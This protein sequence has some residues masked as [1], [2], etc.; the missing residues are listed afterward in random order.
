MDPIVQLG[1]D[2]EVVTLGDNDE[3][4]SAVPAHKIPDVADPRQTIAN[5]AQ[6]PKISEMPN[7]PAAPAPVDYSD[8]GHKVKA[9]SANVIP[10]YTA[11]AQGVQ[12][13]TGAMGL[14]HMT[15]EQVQQDITRAVN[16]NPYSGLAGSVAQNIL[17]T[18]SGAARAIGKL[19]NAAAKIK[20][21]AQLG[22]GLAGANYLTK[23]MNA[24][25][26]KP[27]TEVI[28]ELANEAMT[29]A[30]AGGATERFFPT[31]NPIDLAA[32]YVGP[33]AS[34]W[35]ANWV[36]HYARTSGSVDSE[37]IRKLEAQ[38][39]LKG[40]QNRYQ[41]ILEELANEILP[42]GFFRGG[43]S[44]PMEIRNAATANLRVG[45]DAVDAA[46]QSA[47]VSVP[48]ED[49]QLPFTEKIRDLSVQG[50][51]GGQ[52]A[53]DLVKK[54]LYEH[55]IDPLSR[56]RAGDPAWYQDVP[57]QQLEEAATAIRDPQYADK[58]KLSHPDKSTEMA[59]NALNEIR[60]EA[61]EQAGGL[62]S[63]VQRGL[64]SQANDIYSA[65]RKASEIVYGAEGGNAVNPSPGYATGSVASML[66]RVV[67]GVAGSRPTRSFFGGAKGALNWATKR[68]QSVAQKTGSPLMDA[69]EA[70]FQLDAFKKQVEHIASMN[71]GDQ[72]VAV[73]ALSA[74]DPVFSALWK[75]SQ[76]ENEQE[77]DLDRLKEY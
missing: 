6:G 13:A 66:G 51:V 18:P 72:A 7:L 10:G 26:E 21:M 64:E 47:R 49:L 33:K 75:K 41:D 76:E 36:D 12:A 52:E 59:S 35:A 45:E 37:L 62:P 71:P 22:S 16:E 48:R 53:S 57:L 25:P 29:G 46:R 17:L 63:D 30:V 50:G 43:G 42:E 9:F 31:K 70:P 15:P 23:T 74:T 77:N 3:V 34:S 1:D 32:Q 65:K 11:A 2:D 28:P 58:L 4:V 67:T 20:A 44:S 24:S 39:S 19:P 56:A 60:Y 8:L 54:Q 61:A 27:A 55:V 38:P 5:A 14:P 69:K 68:L 73:Y 40:F